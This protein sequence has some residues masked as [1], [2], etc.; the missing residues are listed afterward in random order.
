MATQG[1]TPQSSKFR[2]RHACFNLLFLPTNR[3]PNRHFVC[4]ANNAKQVLQE[5]PRT[6]SWA[7]RRS[8]IVVA[9]NPRPFPDER[10]F[11][12]SPEHGWRV[13]GPCCV[14]TAWCD[15]K[16]TRKMDAPTSY[17]LPK[18]TSRWCCEAAPWIRVHGCLSCRSVWCPSCIGSKA[19]HISNCLN[20]L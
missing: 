19:R 11:G 20:F 15:L 7:A 6:R 9:R 13:F 16:K 10:A 1:C 18:P 3:L 14:R 4:N 5:T 2:H 12:S 8:H 17:R